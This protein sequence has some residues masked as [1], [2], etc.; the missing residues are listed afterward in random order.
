MLNRSAAVWKSDR[1]GRGVLSL[2]VSFKRFLVLSVTTFLL[3]LLVGCQ[4]LVPK[5]P[6]STGGL[7]A[8]A[9]QPGESCNCSDFKYQEDAQFVLDADK[10]DPHRLDGQN[11]NGKACES[12][13]SRN[14]SERTPSNPL[15]E[16]GSS[17]STNLHLTLGNPSKATTSISNADNY[18]M[19]KPQYALSY[20][21]TKGTPNWVS[22]QLNRSW[23]GNTPRQNN[24]R[25]DES[26]PSGWY[27]VKPSDYTNTGYDK[28]HMA[29]SADRT[30]TVKDNQ[31]TFLMTNMIP[32]AP[33]NNQAPWADLEEYCRDLVNQQ[34]KEL[35]IIAGPEGKKEAIASGK[36]TVPTKTWKIIVVL[37]RP[38]LGVAGV[39][40]NTRVIAIEMPNIQGIRNKNWQI[41][42]TTV[43]KLEAATGYNFLSNVPTSIQN[44]IENRADNQ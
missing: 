37:D 10:S 39:S 38:G 36:V 21:Q 26:L 20:N 12:L 35:Y 27:Q 28:G 9:R 29:P 18:L 40:S 14:S 6:V 13:P 24:F 1:S 32:Q 33:D 43:R 41:Y 44:V 25:P 2:F 34:G 17:P 8:C 15:P 11:K 3:A 31:A 19:V 23:L 16:T 4:V 30:K 7:P 42:R 22:W 5:A